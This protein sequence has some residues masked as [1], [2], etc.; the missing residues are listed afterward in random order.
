MG[1]HV[2]TFEKRGAILLLLLLTATTAAGCS[3][4]GGDKVS[5]DNP[6]AV[7]VILV[8]VSKSTFGQGGTQRQAYLDT[9]TKTVLPALPGG[10]VIKADVVDAKPL[11]HGTTPVSAYFEKASLTGTSDLDAKRSRNRAIKELT[12][13]FEKL[14]AQ[15]PTGNA[16]LDS[17]GQAQKVF[18][19][20]P[21]AKTRYLL[22]FSDMFE[23]ST[24]YSFKQENLAP[25]KVRRFIERERNADRL[26]DL[27]G[28]EVYVVGAGATRGGDTA[29][30]HVR[31]VEQFWL[32]YL[33]ATGARLSSSR[34]GPTLVR[35][36]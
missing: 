7:A 18:D 13:S 26:P 17:L 33:R 20:Y 36:P 11:S 28:V 34:Y 19:S 25:D 10:T 5:E 29:P 24:R 27:S 6:Q 8:D 3:V 22:I 35:F 2:S 12:T 14:M 16:I 1:V 15:H 4:I 31:A 32:N 30:Q 21:D 23:N 9:L